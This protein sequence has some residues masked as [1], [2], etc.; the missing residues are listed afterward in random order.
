MPA[1]NTTNTGTGLGYSSTNNWYGVKYDSLFNNTTTSIWKGQLVQV[2]L[3][4]SVQAAGL[5]A[6]QQYAN[7]ASTALT[8]NVLGVALADCS[9][10]NSSSTATFQAVNK[11]GG[12]QM[13]DVAY[14]GACLVAL[15]SGTV[16]ANNY[17]FPST[18][19]V[20]IATTTAAYMTL[21]AS[22]ASS[23]QSAAALGIVLSTSPAMTNSTGQNLY[24]C[25]LG[26][27]V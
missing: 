24:L 25:Y 2:I 14:R 15:T 17:L 27:V 5:P 9:V 18:S 13:V 20:G 19:A 7:V 21:N 22:T 6:V 3:D 10:V 8:G 1:Q 23:W 11:S 4:T 16:A 26:A 12:P